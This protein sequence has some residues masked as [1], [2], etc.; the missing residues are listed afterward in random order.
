MMPRQGEYDPNRN[1]LLFALLLAISTSKIASAQPSA[2][3]YSSIE[4]SSPAAARKTLHELIDD[5]KKIPYTSEQVDTWDVIVVADEDPSDSTMVRTIY[6]G[7]S[8]PKVARGNDFF[9]R[10]H[11]WPKSYGFPKDGPSNYPYTDLHHL[12]AADRS[13][14]SSRNNL[15]YGNCDSSCTEKPSSEKPVQ[16]AVFEW[17]QEKSNWRRGIGPSGIWEVRQERR[18][19]IARAMF[20]M[21][22][23]YEGG[24]HNKTGAAEPDLELT[25]NVSLI[26]ASNKGRN[27]RKAFMG[28]LSSLVEWHIQDPVD[29][30]EIRRNNI[31]EEYQGNRN[32]FV[33][34]PHFVGLIFSKKTRD[35]D[36]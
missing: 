32:P 6:K 11:A 20:Y 1:A 25:D 23:R 17:T 14:N 36:E 28:R 13:Y 9:N 26:S 22:I 31:I 4:A 12:F 7:A 30:T 15:P 27:T 35:M 16:S 5:H 10:E 21:A 19:D 34:N 18:G 29:E 33:D 2:S 8:Y 3:Y 24:F